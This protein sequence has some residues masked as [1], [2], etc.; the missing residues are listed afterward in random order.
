MAAL[1]T[2]PEVASAL[3]AGRPVVAL[4]S[5]VITHGLPRDPLPSASRL[6]V[7]GW[8]RAAP[9]NLELA[10]A[11]DRTVRETGAV[12]A[13]VAM[14]GGRLVAGLDDETLER[15]AEDAD[16]AKASI[17]DLASL[18]AAKRHAGATVSATLAACALTHHDALAA[19]SR[20]GGA[21]APPSLPGIRVFAT[22][23]IGGV[24]RGWQRLPDVSA[25]LRAIGST[26]VCVVCAG[27]K[28]ILDLPATLEAL[29]ALG[30]PV[31][32]HRTDVFPQF[33]CVGDQSLRIAPGKRVEDA[34]QAAAICRAEWQALSLK[35][36][37]LLANPVPAAHAMDPSRLAAAVE[38]AERMASER[39]I[40]GQARTPFLLA[41]IARLTEGR[42][43]DAN[44][45]LL[46][47]N[48]RL[49]GE[50]ACR[51]AEPG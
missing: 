46:L 21:F 10:R 28:S 37:I 15:L 45:A 13:T 34:R 29:E 22:G 50:L 42:S 3:S 38:A 31:L 16:A 32:G 6:N 23:G 2:N 24:H 43:L 39:G 25:D 27:A 8:D 5:A 41:E 47:D 30:V 40:A 7:P 14:I 1:S 48:A 44:I 35:S 12:P 17:S 51:L 19:R 4:E 33:Q 49:A 26:P 9:M 11:M 18:A 36:G 20:S